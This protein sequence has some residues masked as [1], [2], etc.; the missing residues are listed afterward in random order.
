MPLGGLHKRKS[1]LRFAF[2]GL[3]GFA[4]LIGISLVK[5]YV[6]SY[7]IASEIRQL[8]DQIASL[9]AENKRNSDLV[10]Y[11]KTETYFQQQARLKLGVKA[12]GEK[13]IVIQNSP[14]VVAN[15]S[16]RSVPT[17]AMALQTFQRD[18]RINPRKWFDY[19]FGKE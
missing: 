17:G 8:R 10:E 5:E 6:R 9:E 19:F 12:P 18:D 11:L 15:D 16:G 13:L 3:I 4:V 1:P 2:L 7:Q 14:D